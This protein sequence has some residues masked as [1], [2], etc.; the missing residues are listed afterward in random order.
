MPAVRVAVP[1]DVGLRA[2]RGDLSMAD[3]VAR[4]AEVG[5]KTDTARI[6]RWEH[7]ETPGAD[8][9]AALVVALQVSPAKILSAIEETQKWADE[10]RAPVPA[11]RPRRKKA[12]AS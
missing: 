5:C 8:K 2:L 9:L 6:M 11:P 12:A 1:E 4:L 7:G 10:Q 3:L